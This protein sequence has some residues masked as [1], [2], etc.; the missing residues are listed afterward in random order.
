MQ[1]Q[2][3]FH[4]LLLDWSYWP[5]KNSSLPGPRGLEPVPASILLEWGLNVELFFVLVTFLIATKLLLG[6]QCVTNRPAK[7]TP[8]EGF[9]LSPAPW[10]P[11]EQKR[12]IPNIISYLLTVLLGPL[13][14]KQPSIIWTHSS[15][16][17]HYVLLHDRDQISRRAVPLADVLSPQFQISTK[18][19]RWHPSP[20]DQYIL[21]T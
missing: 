3:E 6:Q 20:G 1:G 11:V 15:I 14:A 19:L 2:L 16:P 10:P 21:D 17:V 8:K 18:L 4:K 13:S 7:F 5:L 12:R 9:L